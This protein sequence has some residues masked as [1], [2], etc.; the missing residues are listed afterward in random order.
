MVAAFVAATVVV[1]GTAHAAEWETSPVRAKW[2]ALGGASF[3]GEKVG[4]EVVLD[5]GIRWAKFAKYDI[6]I[7][8]RD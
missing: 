3:A 7:T 8:W 1:P 2:Q 6:V 4:D 5:N